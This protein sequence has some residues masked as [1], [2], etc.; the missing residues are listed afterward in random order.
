M[1]K[2]CFNNVVLRF[3]QFSELSSVQ[4]GGE[5]SEEILIAFNN[6]IP[7]VSEH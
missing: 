4:L 2:V 6:L 3:L 1:L 5:L 7:V